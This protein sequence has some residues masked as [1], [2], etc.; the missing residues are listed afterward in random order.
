MQQKQNSLHIC[1]DN[2]TVHGPT[3]IFQCTPGTLSLP[4]PL[5]KQRD[6]HLFIPSSASLGQQ[7]QTLLHLPLSQSPSGTD[8]SW[9]SDASHP[10]VRES[11]ISNHHYLNTHI[12]LTVIVKQDQLVRKPKAKIPLK[13]TKTSVFLE[14]P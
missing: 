10:K 12:C 9:M 4:S 1:H 14:L 2:A 3:H 8:M 13:Q 5:Q 6:A 7:C 11:S